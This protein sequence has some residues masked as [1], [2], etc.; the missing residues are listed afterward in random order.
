MA[1]AVNS[2]PA[3]GCKQTAEARARI[4]RGTKWGIA[5]R[6]QLA[7]VLPADLAH[8]QGSGTVAKALLPFFTAAALE[9]TALVL[10]YEGEAGTPGYRPLSAPRRALLDDYLRAGLIM[11]GELAR[12]AQSQDSDASSRAITAMARRAAILKDLGLEHV[13]HTVDLDEHLRRK[14]AESRT[15]TTIDAESEP[16][17]EPADAS[18]TAP[19]ASGAPEPTRSGAAET[20]SHEGA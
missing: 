10:G 16:V 11:R 4:S 19:T 13:E 5:K 6:R 3:K 20:T 9:G 14:A 2:M 18:A 12:Y 7:L 15:G 17:S 1:K 8:L